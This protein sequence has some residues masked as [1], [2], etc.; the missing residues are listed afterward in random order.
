MDYAEGNKA[1]A[2][3]QRVHII[4]SQ[5]DTS[6]DTYNCQMVTTTIGKIVIPINL[7]LSA[8]SRS[9]SRSTV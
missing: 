2:E 6:I 4:D 5:D 3:M 7:S 8:T 1:G 9:Q